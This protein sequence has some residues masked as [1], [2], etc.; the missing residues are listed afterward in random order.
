MDGA[1]SRQAAFYRLPLT[2]IS[3]DRM[4]SLRTTSTYEPSTAPCLL[5]CTT[6]RCRPAL[7]CPPRHQRSGWRKPI[8]AQIIALKDAS[9]GPDSGH[10]DSSWRAGQFRRWCRA[11]MPFSVSGYF[12][13]VACRGDFGAGQCPPALM[14]NS[15]RRLARRS[16]EGQPSKP[17]SCPSCGCFLQSGQTSPA[18]KVSSPSWGYAALYDAPSPSS[19]LSKPPR[20]ACKRPPRPGLSSRARIF[21]ITTSNMRRRPRQPESRYLV[22]LL[23]L[24]S[25]K[26]TDRR[27]LHS[28]CPGGIQ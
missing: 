6:Y 4:A 12:D 25:V 26:S 21:A 28:Q 5:F 1:F 2:T 9:A 15:C 23:L 27:L 11:M 24:W 13:G 14:K 20:P 22:C 10:G 17:S 19:R 18:S 7:I 8:L 3:P 16:A